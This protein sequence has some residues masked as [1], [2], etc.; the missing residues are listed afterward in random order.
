MFYIKIY[1]Y[2]IENVNKSYCNIW[3][4]YEIENVNTIYAKCNILLMYIYAY[5]CECKNIHIHI[6]IHHPHKDIHI[7][8][9]MYAFFQLGF[10]PWRKKAKL[11]IGLLKTFI[12]NTISKP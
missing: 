1:K 12:K 8:P 3:Y 11:S 4:N 6:N 2:E 10:R 5:T 9:N 7:H